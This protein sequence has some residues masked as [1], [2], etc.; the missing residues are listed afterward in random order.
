MRIE[1]W[2]RCQTAN[3]CFNASPAW[4]PRYLVYQTTTSLPRT[5]L[6]VLWVEGQ[7][8]KPRLP[9]RASANTAVGAR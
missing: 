7:A 9:D 6:A 3:G 8:P 5:A 2:R 1:R 4:Q